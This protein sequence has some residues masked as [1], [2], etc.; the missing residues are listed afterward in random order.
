MACA[1]S[2]TCDQYARSEASS[3]WKRGMSKPAEKTP[4]EDANCRALIAGSA[5]HSR[6]PATISS[7]SAGVSALTGFDAI[8]SLA[9]APLFSTVT[10]A[11]RAR[12][13]RTARAAAGA[14]RRAVAASMVWAGWWCGCVRVL[15]G[16]AW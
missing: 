16:W 5:S 15:R 1:R 3:P 10:S 13:P 7:R 8:V 14:A 11:L 2:C 6:M 4:S 12:R 9:T